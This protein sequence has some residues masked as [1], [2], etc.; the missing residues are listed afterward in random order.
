MWK[1]FAKSQYKISIPEIIFT[2][3]ISQAP[4]LF[5]I[6]KTT[7]TLS[8]HELM[9]HQ[10]TNYARTEKPLPLVTNTVHFSQS[11]LKNYGK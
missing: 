7:S 6:T 5:Y 2:S 8:I 4:D 10:V 9:A 11:Q 1:Y 3:P